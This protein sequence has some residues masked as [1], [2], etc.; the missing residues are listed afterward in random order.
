MVEEV[1]WEEEEA[2]VAVE[3][4]VRLLD[5][6]VKPCGSSQSKGQIRRPRA[7]NDLMKPYYLNLF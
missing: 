2:G 4:S 7:Y 3:D 5:F 1:E 6:Q